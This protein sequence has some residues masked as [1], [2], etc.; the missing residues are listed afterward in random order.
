[1]SNKLLDIPTCFRPSRPHSNRLHTQTAQARDFSVAPFLVQRRPQ[2]ASTNGIEPTDY[3]FRNA[4]G[5]ALRSEGI[6]R[7]SLPRT[8]RACLQASSSTGEQ[9]TLIKRSA[10]GWSV[11]L[12]LGRLAPALPG[13]LHPTSTT[14]L[15]VFHAGFEARVPYGGGRYKGGCIKGPLLRGTASEPARCSVGE[16]LYPFGTLRLP[17]FSCSG[18]NMTE[19][20]LKI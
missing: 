6:T 10:A 5:T 19:S 13:P 11:P 18:T 3:S 12:S 15:H 16:R 8:G 4:D 14:P 9:W 7:E 17:V 20:R 2:S 1:M